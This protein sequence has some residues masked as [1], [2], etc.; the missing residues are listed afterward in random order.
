MKKTETSN[1]MC[2]CGWIGENFEDHH[3]DTSTEDLVH[4]ETSPL[5]EL[6]LNK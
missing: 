4:V 1:E 3:K 2:C 6:F 5:M